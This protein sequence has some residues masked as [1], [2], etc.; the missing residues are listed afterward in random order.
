MASTLTFNNDEMVGN[1][2]SLLSRSTFLSAREGARQNNANQIQKGNKAI[3]ESGSMYWDMCV[4]SLKAQGVD[5]PS[6]MQ[7]FDEME[8]V[9]KIAENK[10]LCE[11][12]YP[13]GKDPKD[14]TPL[15]LEAVRSQLPVGAGINFN[16]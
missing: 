9:A 7:I 6:I 16:G 1:F 10:A 11:Q 12:L 13:S 2:R 14:M 5:R 3:I 8:R 4:A 15:E